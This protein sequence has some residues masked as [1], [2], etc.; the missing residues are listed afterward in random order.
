MTTSG[1]TNDSKCYQRSLGR[2]INRQVAHRKQRPINWQ[3]SY[4]EKWMLCSARI[5]LEYSP[6]WV[7]VLNP[8]TNQLVTKV[9][10]STQQVLDNHQLLPFQ[11]GL[12]TSK[13]P[14]VGDGAS[15]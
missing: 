1:A 2:K 5:V 10:Q 14:S 7:D 15:S 13:N 3:E 6:R 11:E 4:L 9:P 12:L 8:A